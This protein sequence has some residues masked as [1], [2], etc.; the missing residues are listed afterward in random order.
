MSFADEKLAKM[1][2]ED[3]GLKTIFIRK[4]GRRGEH[5]QQQGDDDDDDDEEEEEE[6]V[7]TLSMKISECTNTRNRTI[8]G[9]TSTSACELKNYD[10]K[11]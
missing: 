6:E 7:F 10:I 11:S 3:I 8:S 2:W 9:R 1:L 4:S 5:E